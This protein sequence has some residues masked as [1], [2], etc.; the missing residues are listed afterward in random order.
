MRTFTHFLLSLRLSEIL[1]E[2]IDLQH[3]EGLGSFARTHLRRIWGYKCLTLFR[4][5]EVGVMEG[6]MW[7]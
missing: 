6:I 3:W 4:Y 7:F 1:Y 5:M 2:R